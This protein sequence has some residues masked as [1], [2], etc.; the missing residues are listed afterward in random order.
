MNVEDEDG[1]AWIVIDALERLQIPYMVTGSVASFLYGEPRVTYDIDII[2]DPSSASFASLL[3][4]LEP[5]ADVSREAAM[6]AFRR[7]QMFNAIGFETAEKVD[8]IILK[9]RP[10]SKAAFERRQRNTFKTLSFMVS[11]P[12]DSILSKLSW[13]RRGVSSGSVAMCTGFCENDWTSSIGTISNGGRRSLACVRRW[14][15]F[16]PKSNGMKRRTEHH[17]T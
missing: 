10:Y 8:L 2:I 4:L 11:T 13:A 12:E 16:G 7:H 6:D 3:D 5:H 17:S 9:D 15:N 1:L 14:P